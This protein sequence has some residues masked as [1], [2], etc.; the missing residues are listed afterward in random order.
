MSQSSYMANGS[1]SYGGGHA[2][3]PG[4]TGHNGRPSLTFQSPQ[5]FQADVNKQQSQAPQ[6]NGMPKFEMLLKQ[7]SHANENAAKRFAQTQASLQ[8]TQQQHPQQQPPLQA[9][10]AQAQQP[11]AQA[12]SASPPAA[13]STA[14]TPNNAAGT[15]IPTAMGLGTY[16]GPSNTRGYRPGYGYDSGAFGPATQTRTPSLDDTDA[17]GITA[18]T[19]AANDNNNNGGGGSSGNSGGAAVVDPAL[20]GPPATPV[21]KVGGDGAMGVGKAPTPQRP[22]V[23]PISDVGAEVAAAA[24]AAAAASATQAMGLGFGVEKDGLPE[25]EE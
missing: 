17:A 11:Q 19:T 12:Q 5:D 9:P 25:P 7:L 20:A 4:Y 21:G 10:Q 13:A 8:Q 2:Y 1:G 15:Q 16:T 18:T 6:M 22:A 24:A 14:L 23:S 3:G